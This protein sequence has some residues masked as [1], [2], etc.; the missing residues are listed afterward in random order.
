MKHDPLDDFLREISEFLEKAQ[1]QAPKQFKES[2]P[3]GFEDQL[4]QLENAVLKFHEKVV[5]EAHKLGLTDKDI[6]ASSFI[7]PAGL[8]PKQQET[9]RKATQL[10]WDAE[11]MKYVLKQIQKRMKEPALTPKTVK[12]KQ[13]A[14]I[15]R[16]QRFRKMGGDTWQKL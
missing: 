9:W 16:R 2:L 12:Q 8:T 6:E 3:A 5:T 13:K 15:K 10:R 14:I 1:E 7:M 11:G 4:N